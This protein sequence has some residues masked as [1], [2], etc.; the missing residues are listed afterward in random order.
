MDL[1]DLLDESSPVKTTTSKAVGID[2]KL[3]PSTKISRPP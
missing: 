3:K 1:D 2:F